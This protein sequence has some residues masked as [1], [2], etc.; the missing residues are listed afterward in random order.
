MRIEQ[1]K[2]TKSKTDSW[3][4]LEYDLEVGSRSKFILHLREALPE[5]LGNVG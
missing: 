3:K 2:V 5:M 4:D 1:S